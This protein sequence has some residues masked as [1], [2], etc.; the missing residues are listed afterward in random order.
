MA[1]LPPPE[2]LLEVGRIGKPHGVR[3]DVFI[4]LTSN[5]PERHAPGATFTII[6][7]AGYRVLTIAT[8]RPQADRWVVHFEGVDDRNISE[9]LTNRYLYAAPLDDD[10]ALWVHELIGSRVVGKDGTEWGTCT[11]VLQNPA[12]DILEIDDTLLVPMPFVLS[13][14]DGVTTIDPPAGLR[15]ALM[16]STPDDSE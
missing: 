15:E 11:G 7:P 10:D 2:G 6:E 13:C 12:H 16:P 8:S 9:K 1:T 3:G 5:S 14:E 4:S